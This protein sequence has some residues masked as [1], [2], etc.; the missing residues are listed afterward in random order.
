MI[1]F[2]EFLNETP[3]PD[4]WD[5]S[6][7]QKNVPFKKQIEYAVAR[8]LKLGKGSSR[9]A[10]EIE[11]KGRP[12][13]LKIAHN[14]KGLLQNKAEAE[15]LSDRFATSLDILIPLIDYDEQNEEPGWIHIEKA[16]KVTEKKLCELLRTPKLIALVTVTQD[17][18]TTGNYYKR[19]AESYLRSVK[20]FNN[21]DSEKMDLFYEYSD[22]LLTLANSFKLELD[23]C[24]DARNWGIY[25]NKPVIIDAGFTEEVSAYY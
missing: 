5:A 23:D 8:A 24:S 9:T 12:T 11:Y 22:A 6:V 21:N 13:V 4:S 19:A 16:N 2:E 10:V 18:L 1:S 20:E 17:R 25:N 15:I 3:L 7:Y 14:K